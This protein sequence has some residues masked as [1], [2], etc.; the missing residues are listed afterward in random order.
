[1]ISRVI[2]S[3]ALVSSGVPDLR[4]EVVT[5]MRNLSEIFRRNEIKSFSIVEKI[6]FY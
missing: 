2:G 5:E 6:V 4:I 1:M 3:E